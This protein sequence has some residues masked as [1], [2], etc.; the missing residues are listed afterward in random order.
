MQNLSLALH[1]LPTNAAKYGALSNESGD[2]LDDC[3]D[4]K[5]NILK[6][7]WKER[8]GP[9]AVPLWFGASRLKATFADIRIDYL[10]EG[11]I[12]EID[13]FLGRAQS[14]ARCSHNSQEI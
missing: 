6:F 13:L 9:P 11:P 5:D 7:K 1:E 3:R 10:V 12:C 4:G 2:L 8:G 14:G